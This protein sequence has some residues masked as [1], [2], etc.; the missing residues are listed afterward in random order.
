MAAFARLIAGGFGA[1]LVPKA[2]GTAGALLAVAAGALLLAWS[3]AALPVAAI[4]AAGIGVW[5]V[6]AAGLQGDPGWVV[7]DEVAGQFVAMLP[8]SRPAWPGLLLAFSL[9]RLFDIAKPGPVGWVDRRHG[10]WAVMADDLVAGA[11]AAAVLWLVVQ[12]LRLR[13]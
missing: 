9:F 10:A 3:P 6:A 1:G 12:A 7:I 5:A 11:L 2:P 8:L 13:H 4:L